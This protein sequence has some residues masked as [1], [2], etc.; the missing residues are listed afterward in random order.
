MENKDGFSSSLREVRHCPE[1][2]SPLIYL[3]VLACAH[4]GEER[5]LRCFWYRSG[6]DSYVAECIDLDLLSK[7]DTLETAIGKLQEAMHSYLEVAFEGESTKGLVLR[8]SPLSHRLRYYFHKLGCWFSPRI[9]GL[10][11]RHFLP[12]SPDLE[13]RRLSHC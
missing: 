12:S 5:P 9:R 1:C 10:H 13:K 7:G 11:G 4:C 8:L 6:S 2:G 3:P